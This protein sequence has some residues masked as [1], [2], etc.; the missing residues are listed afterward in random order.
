[1]LIRSSSQTAFEQRPIE[2]IEIHA[3]EWVFEALAAGPT[4]GTEDQAFARE[5]A[6]SSAEYVSGPYEFVVLE[7]VGH[8]IPEEAHAVVTEIVLRHVAP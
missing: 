1:M 5:S 7:G 2:Q 6:E 8:W 3:G 4:D